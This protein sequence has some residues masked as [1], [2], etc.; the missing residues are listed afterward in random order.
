[1]YLSDRG[2]PFT[3]FITGDPPFYLEATLDDQQ[4]VLTLWKCD[5]QG[6]HLS[7]IH[8]WTGWRFPT[9]WTPVELRDPELEL[10]EGI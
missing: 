10:D 6:T 7:Q 1:M 9:D 3:A 5:A 8:G 4:R 2:K